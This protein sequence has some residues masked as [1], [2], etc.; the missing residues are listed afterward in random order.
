MTQV[1]VGQP[2]LEAPPQPIPISG[3]WPWLI[4]GVVAM[5]FFGIL[6]VVL[7]AI[8]VD[9]NVVQ[10]IATVLSLIVPTV[11]ALLAMLK[12]AEASTK[13]DTLHV[14]VNSRLSQLLEQTTIAQH[15]IGKSEGLIEAASVHQT[16]IIPLGLVAA[17]EANT[18]AR[19]AANTQPEAGP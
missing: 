5:T 19:I 2:A 3:S 17:V 1:P 12:S 4:A 10:L 7:I 16:P 9:E 6:G 8:F 18:E 14:A 15:A 11:A 13:V